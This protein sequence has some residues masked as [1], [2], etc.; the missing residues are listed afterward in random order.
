LKMRLLQLPLH[1]DFV[2]GVPGGIPATVKNLL[3][4]VESLPDGST[5]T[6][7]GIGKHELYLG[8]MAIILGGHVR[9]GFEDN[10]Y[11]SRSI[12][13]ESNAQLVAR[14]ARIA[15]EL[16]REVAKPDEARKI[17]GLQPA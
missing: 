12:L 6:V 4:L 16:G 8:V 11:Y 1:F 9:V 5:W 15:G 10:V 13:A 14:I 7:A 2:M 3:H 17:L